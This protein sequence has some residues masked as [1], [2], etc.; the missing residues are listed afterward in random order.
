MRIYPVY[1][2]LCFEGGPWFDDMHLNQTGGWWA[3]ALM[4]ERDVFAWI[5]PAGPSS[6]PRAP[7]PQAAEEIGQTRRLL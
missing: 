5:L 1:V 4:A 3:R 7:R 2:A 6:R